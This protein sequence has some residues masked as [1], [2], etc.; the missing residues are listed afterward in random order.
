MKFALKLACASILFVSVTK[1]IAKKYLS[2]YPLQISHIHV[3]AETV[4]K[5]YAIFQIFVTLIVF[6][7]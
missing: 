7:I 6:E 3:D 4:D 5:Q 2:I 1:N